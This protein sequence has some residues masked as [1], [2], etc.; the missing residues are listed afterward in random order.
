MV[1]S[2]VQFRREHP[3]LSAADAPCDGPLPAVRTNVDLSELE[4]KRN[5]TRSPVRHMTLRHL[6]PLSRDGV[7]T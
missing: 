3:S 1:R 2:I 7:L 5:V 4:R 6:H